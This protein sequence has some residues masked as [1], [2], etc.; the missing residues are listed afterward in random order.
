[1]RVEFD[2]ICDKGL[3]REIN[4]DSIYMK[5]KGETTLLVVADGMG[6]HVKG[7]RA[8][9]EITDGFAKWYEAFDESTYEGDF[10]QMVDDI[11]SLLNDINSTVYAFYDKYTICGSTVVALFIYQNQ[12]AVLWAGDSRAYMKKGWCFKQLTTDDVWENQPE[13]KKNLPKKLIK[14]SV[15]L[16]KL[17]NSIGIYD[18]SNINVKTGT[19]K[20]GTRFLICSD[21]L[22][23]M[24]SDPEIK[25]MMK[26][27]IGNDTGKE[28]IKKYLD[29]VYK[30]GAGDNVSYIV[31]ICN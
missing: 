14:D 22:Y 8:S 2:G 28:Q 18:K 27:Y 5:S 9:Q 21:G 31:A 17:V 3:E 13:I 23:K 16:G 19:I 1:M 20:S 29:T 12:Y 11:N 7:E 4:Q 25:E 30:Y 6:G 10:N 24:C 26:S 15:N